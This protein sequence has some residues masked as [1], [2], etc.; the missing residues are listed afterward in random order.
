MLDNFHV[1]LISL[2]LA[3]SAELDSVSGHAKSEALLQSAGLAAIAIGSVD[4]AVSCAGAVVASVVLLRSA[5]EAF[6]AFAGDDAVVDA[7]GA[8]AADFARDDFD[9][10]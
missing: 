7:G 3:H 10:S 4:D 8:V 9:V 6:A 1:Q 5:E 2:L